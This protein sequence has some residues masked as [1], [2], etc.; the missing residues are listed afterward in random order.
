[1][2]ELPT[3]PPTTLHQHETILPISGA[4]AVESC[5]FDRYSAG[6]GANLEKGIKKLTEFK[7]EATHFLWFER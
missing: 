4:A 6:A 1:L 7:R 5:F 2:T 3:A